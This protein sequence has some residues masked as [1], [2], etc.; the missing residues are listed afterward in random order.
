MNR[1]LLATAICASLFATGTA[2]AQTASSDSQ[3][4][5]NQPQQPS[6]TTTASQSQKKKEKTLQTIT[7]T[8]SLIP[9]SQIETANP[10]ITIT[11]QDMQK[12]GFVNIYDALRSQPLSTGSVQDNQTTAGFTPGAQTIS[13]L[14]LPPDFTLFLL[15]GRPM[16][17]F[18]LLYNGS[19]NFVD[20]SNIPMSMVDHID[21]LPGNQSSIYGSSAIAGVVNV[22]LKKKMDGY[23]LEYRAGGYTD[24]GGQQQRLNFSGGYNTDKLSV[25][26]SVQV[27]DQHPLFGY[28]RDLTSSTLSNPN[29]A[30]RYATPAVI[31]WQ[32]LTQRTHYIDPDLDG[33]CGA[34]SGLFGSTVTRQARNSR[35]PGGVGPGY[36]CGSYTELGYSTLLN[37]KRDASGYVNLTY[38]VND[39]TQL[40]GSLLYDFQKQRFYAGPNYNWWAPANGNYIWNT[41]TNTFDF[42][43]KLF[44]PEEIGGPLA[45]ADN[46]IARM[47]NGDIGIRGNFGNSDWNYEAYFSRADYKVADKQLRPLAG[48]VDTFFEKMFLGPQL[49]LDPNYS[50]YPAYAPNDAAFLKPITPAEY[51]SFSDYIRSTSHTYT[52]LFNAQITNS[53]LFHLPAG[54]VGF[55]A[56]LQGGDQIWDNPTDPRVV[57]GDFWGLTGTSGY[58]KRNNYAAAVEFRV[59]IFSMLSADISARYDHYKNVNAGS[60]SKPTYKIGLEFRPFDTLLLRA[61]YATAFRAPD[62]AS[63]FQGPSGFYNFAT[64]YYKCEKY[65][66]TTA[67]QDCT[68]DNVQYKGT[69]EGNAALKSITAKSWGYGAVWSPT[70]KL[71]VKA[72]YYDVNVK[73]EIMPLSVDGLLRTEAACRLGQL[74]INSGSCVDALTRIQRTPESTNQSQSQNISGITVGP[75]NIATERVKG[76]VAGLDYKLDAARFGDFT[77][78]AQYNVT[79]NHY[80]QQYPTSPNIDLLRHPEWSW[81]NATAAEFKTIFTGSVTWDIGKW[82]ATLA[83]TR[84]GASANYAA[85][86]QGYG[87][88]NAGTVAPW[89][90]YNGSVTYHVTPDITTQLIVNNIKDSMPPRDT[91][92]V[93]WPY[94]NQYNYN[95][96]G[97]ILWLDLNIHFGGK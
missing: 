26:Y 63:V 77:F 33:G 18:P 90:V 68:W 37:R 10:V 58:G 82:S 19:A 83:G 79:L 70:D 29:P 1:K 87:T 51:R 75:I 13:L 39:N 25:L 8:G 89:M 81:A 36:F 35:G 16:A 41:N 69:Q 23:N 5:Q 88:P 73:N 78:G 85:Q 66:P 95:P 6:P 64:D 47:Y 57:A 43:E 46:Q 96:Y 59:P 84:Y 54:D 21:I 7:V 30:A 45:N 3:A 48:P 20:L 27:D 97:R 80:L 11:A 91:T 52:Q 38:Q 49:G 32:G 2:Y 15:N 94:Y 12:K 71:T 67:I 55:A 60:D 42:Y 65:E 4:Q 56:V 86:T 92:W 17:D 50:Y 14:G 24:G 76:I 40:F 53:S 31:H 62:M 44:S 72:D 93:G 22:V 34:L 9:Q 28:N 74:D 61:N